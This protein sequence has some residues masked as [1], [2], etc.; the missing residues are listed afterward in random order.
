MG[1]TSIY[2]HRR[3][4]ALIVALLCAALLAG[5]HGRANAYL[6]SPTSETS[7]GLV[8]DIELPTATVSQPLKAPTVTICNPNCQSHGGDALSSITLSADKGPYRLVMAVKKAAGTYLSYANVCPDGKIGALL[9][10]EG[11]SSAT[12]VLAKLQ[13]AVRNADGTVAK[14]E[15]GNTVFEDI[16]ETVVDVPGSDTGPIDAT[17]G[18][19]LGVS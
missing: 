16:P 15:F 7:V 2:A 8:Q 18:L 11:M 10:I 4:G 12:S 5:N 6:L 14:D 19:C 3:L 9:R 13:Q 17:T 1:T